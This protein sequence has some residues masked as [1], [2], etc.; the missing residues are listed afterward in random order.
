[1]S[2][3]NALG[4][5]AALQQTQAATAKSP[6]APTSAAANPSVSD[7]LELS[8]VGHLLTTLKASGD[9][10]IDKVE[11]IKAQIE[12]GTYDDDAKLDAATDRLLDDVL[13]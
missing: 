4:G 8:G 11:S 2:S 3:I 12:A 13:R 7:R 5:P 10:R 9:V 1:M 6:A